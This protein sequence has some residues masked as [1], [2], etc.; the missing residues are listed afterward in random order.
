LLELTCIQ[1][2]PCRLL[3][4]RVRRLR[5]L[6][7]VGRRLLCEGRDAGKKQK[8]RDRQYRQFPEVRWLARPRAAVR[9]RI[10][11]WARLLGTNR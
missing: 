5:V 6:I 9:R 1:W 11:S 3:G 7:L 4:I 10:G 8:R 2:L